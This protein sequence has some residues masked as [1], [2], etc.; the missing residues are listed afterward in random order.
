MIAKRYD[1]LRWENIY[2]KEVEDVLYSHPKIMDAAIIRIPDQT[3]TEA[4]C[5]HIVLKR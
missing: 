3:W 5:A 4:V 2:S 1:N